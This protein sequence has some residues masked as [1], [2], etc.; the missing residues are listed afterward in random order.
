ML[1]GQL[2]TARWERIA[3][4]MPLRTA[5]QCRDRYVNYLADNLCDDEWTAAEDAVIFQKMREIGPKW[6]TIAR[7][8]HGRSENAVKNRWHKHLAK[9]MN[10]S[11]ALFP[12]LRPHPLPERPSAFNFPPSGPSGGNPGQFP[13]A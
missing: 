7:F 5:K 10:P 12:F 3:S 1:V 11:P 8:L 13:H 4:E 9:T 2:G 6:A